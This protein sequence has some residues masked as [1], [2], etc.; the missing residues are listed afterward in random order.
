MKAALIQCP[1]S[2]ISRK[3][4]NALHAGIANRDIRPET[5]LT[6]WESGSDLTRQIVDSGAAPTK[7]VT[8]RYTL[9]SVTVNKSLTVGLL[10]GQ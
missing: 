3:A 9:L 5:T 10:T 4:A 2:A 1:L 7:G 6:I 8:I